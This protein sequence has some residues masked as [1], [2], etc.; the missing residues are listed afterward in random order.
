VTTRISR[1]ALR[2]YLCT[3]RALAAGRDIAALVEEAVAG[4]VTCVQLREKNI[5]SREFFGLA[6]R[7]REVTRR[8]RVPLIINDRFDIAL[9]AGADGVHLGRSDLPVREARRAAGPRFVIGASA[10]T[11][12]EALRAEAEGADYL[13]AGAVFSTGTKR[14]AGVI[15]LEGLRR[16]CAAARI[17]VAGI[18]GVSAGNAAAV[19]E[20]GAAGI[21]VISALLARPDVRAAAAELRGAVEL[22]LAANP[23][24]LRE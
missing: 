15:G 9:A 23:R 19:V 24:K 4:G 7:M 8:L 10:S 22:S 1:D 2:L 16:V 6:V 11:P 18:G 21:A 13:G 17:P 20:A 14:D 5:P 12:E 3:D